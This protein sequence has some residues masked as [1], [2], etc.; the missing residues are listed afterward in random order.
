M[1]LP[2]AH[3]VRPS[4]ANSRTRGYCARGGARSFVP[5]SLRTGFRGSRPEMSSGKNSSAR[6]L[7]DRDRPAAYEIAAPGHLAKERSPRKAE[8]EQFSVVR[9]VRL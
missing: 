8:T 2:A 6:E 3:Y 7:D 9:V 5:H 1:R 4:G